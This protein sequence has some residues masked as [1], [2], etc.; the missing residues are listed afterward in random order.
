MR[1]LAQVHDNLGHKGFLPNRA[2]LYSRFW[3][4]SAMQDLRWYVMTCQICQERNTAKF[5][6]PP[7]VPEPGGLFAQIHIDTFYMPQHHGCWYIIHAVD[8]LTGWP[9]AKAL[10]KKMLRQLVTL[11]LT[12]FSAGLVPFKN[13]LPIIVL[14]L[15]QPSII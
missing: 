15:C 5:A 9:E 3:W 14:L 1:I 13:S 8:S 10:L 11:F 2:T 12:V 4:P 6:I 7:T